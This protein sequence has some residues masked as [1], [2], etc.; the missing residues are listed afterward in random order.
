MSE[1]ANVPITPRH[2]QV[3]CALA[4][5]T[6]F[7]LQMQQGIDLF[8]NLMTLFAGVLGVFYRIRIGPI[9]VMIGLAAGQFRDQYYLNEFA[10]P[11]HPASSFNV[12]TLALSMAVLT[13]IVG[14][15]RLQGLWFGV[16]PSDRRHEST[17]AQARSTASLTPAELAALVVPI[18]LCAVLADCGRFILRQHWTVVGLPPRWKQFFAAA[19]FVLLVVF[20]AAHAFRYWRRLQMDRATA[21]MLLQDLLWN[22]TRGEQRRLNR[23]IVWR[24]LKE[25]RGDS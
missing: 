24:K 18:P 21:Q 9:A 20:V 25:T 14:Q 5:A 17:A 8:I 3:L 12:E 23:W 13:Y 19:W 10:A 2:Y 16:L 22:E 7:I 4:L 1:P 15:Y 6:V 11:I